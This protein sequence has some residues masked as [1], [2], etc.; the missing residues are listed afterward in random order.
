[1]KVTQLQTQINEMNIIQYT[2]SYVENIIYFSIER[3]KESYL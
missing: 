2:H 1:M 3:G